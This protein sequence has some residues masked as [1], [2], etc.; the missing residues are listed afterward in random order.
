MKQ[1]QWNISRQSPQSRSMMRHYS[2]T[3]HKNG[4]NYWNNLNSLDFNLKN[5]GKK[6]GTPIEQARPDNYKR[7]QLEQSAPKFVYYMLEPDDYI[8]HLMHLNIQYSQQLRTA[9]KP[10]YKRD[11]YEIYIWERSNIGRAL[12]EYKSGLMRNLLINSLPKVTARF[13]LRC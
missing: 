10:V 3:T 5:A 11:L 12:D 1:W 7:P 13:G 8:M 4:T 2:Y 6:V 9:R